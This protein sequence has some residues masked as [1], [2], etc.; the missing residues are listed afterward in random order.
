MATSIFKDIPPDVR[1]WREK[2]F[3]LAN[4]IL[5]SP[6][7]FDDYFHYV[8]NVYKFKRRNTST[9]LNTGTFYYECR[10]YGEPTHTR[11]DHGNGEYEQVNKK[12]RHTPRRD[13]DQC[14]VK[15][16]VV[17]R[18]DENGQVIS[19][20]ITK[21]DVTHHTHDLDRSDQI[22][23]NSGVRDALRQEAEKLYSPSAILR[24]ASNERSL[25]GREILKQI[26]GSHVR[27]QIFNCQP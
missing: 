20:S 3:A 21:T 7:E 14:N 15:M 26:G 23:R 11:M 16:K 4:E 8:D 6:K 19:Y 13:A 10:L 25:N 22:K 1:Q 18:R 12:R 2:L 27:P 9:R 5:M 17:R 24:I